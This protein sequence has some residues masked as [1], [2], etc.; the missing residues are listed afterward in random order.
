MFET[1]IVR[2]HV[3]NGQAIDAGLLAETL[4]FYDNIHIVVDAGTLFGLANK[5]G[6]DNVLSLLEAH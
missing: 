3:N 5:I 4:L 6:T 2:R 1:I